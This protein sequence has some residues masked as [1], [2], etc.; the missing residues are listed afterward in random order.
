MLFPRSARA[1]T[2]RASLLLSASI[3]CTAA[4]QVTFRPVAPPPKAD[5]AAPNGS[6]CTLPHHDRPANPVGGVAGDPVIVVSETENN[7]LPKSAQPIPLGTGD[8]ESRS[9]NVDGTIAT[10]VDVD[11]FRFSAAAGDIISITAR[12]TGSLD[13]VVAVLTTDGAL[14]VGNDDDFFKR[15]VYPPEAPFL[16][17]SSL[18][19]SSVVWIAPFSGDFTIVVTPFDTTSSGGYQLLVRSFRPPLTEEPPP[20]EQTIYLEFNG[21]SLNAAATFG[22]GATSA[23]LSPL[24]SF[25]SAW[26]LSAGDESAVIDAII[27]GFEEN[28]EDLRR[29]GINGDRDA[30]GQIGDFDYRVLNSRDHADPF[31]QPNVSRII[32]GGRINQLG[33]ET[34]GIAESIDPGNFAQEETAVVLLDLLS[35]PMGDPNSIN[36]IPR[37]AGVSQIDAIGLVVGTIAAHEA[38]HYLGN[39]HTDTLNDTRSIMDSGGFLQINVAGVGS[40]GTLGTGDDQDVD[41]S[42]DAVQE[43]EFLVF[44]GQFTDARTAFALSTGADAPVCEFATG[45]CCLAQDEGDIGCSETSCCETVCAIQ[46]ACCTDR[47]DGMCAQLANENC[48]E[49]FPYCDWC[50]GTLSCCG[51]NFTPG[52]NRGACCDIVC[53][54]DPSCCTDNW[55][56]A[57]AA[58]A[59][60]AC[61]PVLCDCGRLGDFDGDDWSDLRDVAAF[62]N[63]AIDETGDGIAPDCACG[64]ANGDAFVDATDFAA[65]FPAGLEGPD[66]DLAFSSAPNADIPD[67]GGPGMPLV[68]SIFVPEQLQISDVNVHLNIRHS[69][70]GDLIVTLRHSGIEV[71]LIDRPLLPGTSFGCGLADYDILLSDEATGG[72]IEDLCAPIMQSPPAYVAEEAL[73]AFD[74]ISAFGLW[75]IEI[76]DNEAL[77]TGVLEAWTID[78]GGD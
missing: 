19:D 65:L 24:S 73:S 29:A 27:A 26:G 52:C 57:C 72:P 70:V 77:D 61:S 34:I 69:F 36:S 75:Q 35:A 16:L 54:I 10:G 28:F 43:Q 21:A 40:D 1:R 5:P 12:A 11:F 76:S 15:G 49:T 62:M 55:S 44:G 25:L 31:G 7:D 20:A 33:I 30:S 22:T 78:F 68:R 47:W 46:P 13:T 58:R 32:I 23:N 60:E 6:W 18:F 41:F 63:C 50:P 14:F 39:F 51:L 74:G 37:A 17:G 2:N 59:R 71:V 38:G 56:D 3:T 4:A 53:G 9:V 66:C 45:D 67:D 8:G 42:L 48:G 64:D